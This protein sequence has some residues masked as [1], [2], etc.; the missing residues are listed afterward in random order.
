ML[1]RKVTSRSQAF[2]K[3]LLGL[4]FGLACVGASAQGM[5]SKVIGVC[6][7]PSAVEVEAT[8]G[9]MGPTGYTT[10]RLAF[11]A[12]NA[13]THQG[14]INIE[15]CL[16]TTEGA[17]P[18][19]L[20]SSGAGSALYTTVNLRPLA[21]G[22]SISGSPITGFGVIQ[23]NGADSVTIDGDNPNSA[24]VNRNLTVN[25]T[26]ATAVIANSVIRV[27]TS[28]AVTSANDI[29]IRNLNLNGNVLSGNASGIV[30]TTSSS[31][32]S[33]GIYVGGGGGASAIGA[34]TAITSV[35]AQSAPTVTTINNL[36][37]SNNA[38][39]QAARGIVINGAA[40]TVINGPTVSNNILGGAGA[41]AG[42]TPYN[43]PAT[44]IYTKGIWVAGANNIV[45][46]GNTLQNI[47]SYVATTMSAIEL[48][49]AIGTPINISGNNVGTV[50]QNGTV[51]GAR[52]IQ[53]SSASGSYLVADNAINN[54]QSLGT[55]SGT[56]AIELSGT[57]TSGIAERNRISTV[58]HR[59][60]GTWGAYGLNLATGTAITVRNNFIRDI[61]MDM[62]GGDAFDTVF[63]VHGLRVN[64]GTGHRIYNN[65][66]N[67]SG[68]LLGTATPS[69]M[70]S[71][72]MIAATGL[73]GIDMRNNICANTITGGTTSIAH[74][75]L[76]L[77]SAGTAAMNLTLDSNDYFSGTDAATQG[78]AQVG[79][80]AGTGF[81]LGSNFSAGATTPSSNLRSYSDTL[82]ATTGNDSASII[83]NPG[84]V[85]ATD[86]HITLGSAAQNS[87]AT[88]ASVTNDIDQQLRPGGGFY[89]IGADEIDGIT[90]FANDIA[91]TEFIDPTNG[92]FKLINTPFSPQASFT[93][94]GT[95]TQT[96]V[97]VRYRIL[98]SLAFEV[99]N[100]TALIPSIAF[101]GVVTVTF[102]P[103]A[104]S[105]TG[106]YT[107][108]ALAELPGDTFPAN[109]QIN[110]TLTMA[111]PLAG[112]YTV[113][114]GGTFASL[115][116]NAGLFQTINAR[117]ASANLSVTIISDL[118]GET[119]ANAL[120]QIA[121]G[122]TLSIQPTGARIVSGVSAAALIDLNGAD[123]VTIDGLN[124][125][126]NSL[127][128]RN[129]TNGAVRLINDASNNILRNLTLETATGFTGIS[130][131]SGSVTGNDDNLITRNVVRARTDA[132]SLPFNG[133]GSFA[134]LPGAINSNLVISDN[135]IT[136]FSGSGIVVNP[137]TE[138][139][140]ITGNTISQETVR[141]SAVVGINHFGSTGT[142]LVSR[143]T[144]RDFSN[145]GAFATDGM[146]FRDARSTTV[147]RN[148]IFNFSN[149]PGATG[150]IGGIGS[151]GSSAG[152]AATVLT[153]VNNM[154]TIAPAAFSNQI[155]WGIYDFGF[156]GNVFTADH[157]S[158]FIGGSG[159]GSSA[160]WAIVRRNF[161]PTTFTARNNLAFNARSG[162]GNHFAAGDQSANTG[163]YVSDF[164]FFAGTGT[165]AANFMDRGAVAAG[166]AVSIATWQAGPPARDA[167]S[168]AGTAASFVASDIYVDVATGDLHLK[169]T[170]GAVLN[171]GTPLAGV[172]TD[173]DNDLR[174]A[175]T[176]DIG[177]DELV[178]SF[179]V[180][181]NVT[182]L[183]GSGLVLQ[184][185]LGD[186]L[187]IGAN[188]VFTF[189]TSVATG[190]PY[191]VTVF[192]Q[193][194]S[195]TQTCTVT[196]GSGTMG[197]A[198]VTNVA[199][200]CTTN[201][202][203]VGGTVSGLTGS[204]LVLQN[205]GGNNLPISA[206]GAFTF[207]TPVPS[208]SLYAVTVLTQPGTPTQTCVVTNGSGTIG[209][210]N[211]TNVTVAC[212]N[213]NV[214]PTI[215]AVAV[216]RRSGD[217]V[218]NSTIA[219]VNDAEDAENTLA[220]TANGLA[221]ATVNGVTVSGISVS[222][223]GVVTANVVAACGATT[224]NFTLRVTDAGAL[225]AEA[226]LTV[227]VDANLAPV[228]TYTSPQSVVIGQGLTINP[229]TGPSDT[230]PISSITLLSQGTY[231]GGIS[232]N[233]TT[234][235]VTLTSAAP[236]GTHTLTIR[237]AD[238]CSLN[239]DAT[240]TLTVTP[241]ANL[242]IVKQSSLALLQGGMMQYT[243]TAT[244]PGPSAVTGARIQDTFAGS[245]SNV[246]WTCAVTNSATC[247]ANGSGNIDQLVNLPANSTVVY[248]ITATVAQPLPQSI[249][250]TA[251]IT[252]PVN[253]PDPVV[254]NNTS[255]VVDQLFLFRDGFE[256]LV[257]IVAS[258]S[259]LPLA[260]VGIT[261]SLLLSRDAAA[262]AGTDARAVE[263]AAFDIDGTFA[264]VQARRVGG[265]LQVRLLQRNRNGSW[266]VGDWSALG[267]SA[268]SFE[269]SNQSAAAG[270]LVVTALRFGF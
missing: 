107:I 78:I 42:A 24:G 89:D 225:F 187:P 38:I 26:T 118:S 30:G 203:T 131:S 152:A 202:Y 41:N 60:P 105:A 22:L 95:A 153:I 71:A 111:T 126:G 67:L 51:N 128:I 259:S 91:A 52:G 175:T 149:I 47:L 21:D 94:S 238:S 96:N 240:I 129:T 31:N 159:S 227:T 146:I 46:T 247:T 68:A 157:N 137:G 199:V 179:T 168:I 188:G 19:T 185:N 134:T 243:I 37:I 270:S 177:A 136:E 180:G 205:N 253:V 15:V 174:S 49:T 268:L 125:S 84:F 211:V 73:T 209:A 86:L 145:S 182:G 256:D 10:V 244:N 138:S 232:V 246:T 261:E 150:T 85:S 169:S 214:A 58:Y 34:P 234:G 116:N 265:E 258:T 135:V 210:A 48:A 173:F 75:S 207:T 81:Y 69:I 267:T 55:G 101:N 27:A 204:G 79:L 140:T 191:A 237:A 147:S 186:N 17:T 12:I 59:N 170:A 155:I 248:A 92:G 3:S 130:I 106:N 148:R 97:P 223:A 70:T 236:A 257:S 165:T 195:P 196:D 127:L 216:T 249:S 35:T 213:N 139:I 141:S 90:P 164:N 206:N 231:T 230:G 82:R 167:S 99:Y 62:S 200:S 7:T 143:N 56:S 104:I 239:T 9:T 132:A 266:M 64:G 119:G 252:A 178:F 189:A 108:I 57:P 72:C 176:P 18:A 260:R 255:T 212:S 228:L 4:A 264:V 123:G 154:V 45:I 100:Q 112:A 193:P 28:T 63:S 219:N 121:G 142:N 217:L 114:T 215:S 102:P 245:L 25:N 6:D 151:F 54:I 109:D 44:T 201:T 241:S 87:G 229:A 113:G 171:G 103:L 50:S 208:G 33:F 36:V 220:V 133:I 190:A 20:N 16:S 61:L 198:N 222:A 144:I 120:N 117:G 235:V 160:S 110:G 98:N 181:G 8:A 13:G 233:N 254:G 14:A 1:A 161:A 39:N 263:F 224:A 242:S 65:S 80:V 124:S 250:N 74:V 269:W 172:T 183:V 226:T 197:A 11:D 262:L 66:V 115:T 184:N 53:I 83:T 40:A 163:T 5:Q 77:P 221:S 192:T 218:S 166:T 29:S 93:N 251:T 2:I 76:Y 23:L 156:T 122:V 162:I 158:V 88:I 32:S 194:G 43:M